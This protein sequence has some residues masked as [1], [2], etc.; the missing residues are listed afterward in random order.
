[1]D[2]LN[3]KQKKYNNCVNNNDLE[4]HP[5]VIRGVIRGNAILGFGSSLEIF[6]KGS[7]IS[8]HESS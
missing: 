5:S 4:D 2:M 8:G 1:M 6:V 3:E 7:K